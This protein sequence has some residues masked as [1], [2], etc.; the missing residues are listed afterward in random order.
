MEYNQGA[1]YTKDEYQKT[2][3]AKN[4]NTI[5]PV[6]LQW[7]SEHVHVDQNKVLHL[8]QQE[9]YFV[10]FVGKVLQI[11]ERKNITEYTV[12]DYTGSIKCMLSLINKTQ[13]NMV[14][15]EQMI[16]KGDYVYVVAR[17][18]RRDNDQSGNQ[19]T[20]YWASKIKRIEDH[21]QLTKHYLSCLVEELRARGQYVQPPSKRDEAKAKLEEAEAAVY[22]CLDQHA[23]THN[24]ISGVRED[25]ILR[26][27]GNVPKHEVM[28]VLTSIQ[29]GQNTKMGSDET[30][31]FLI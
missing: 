28:Q 14:K 30:G 25:Q 7:L 19:E 31:Y 6:L 16:T 10:T 17:G 20:T 27:C 24:Q 13:E 9:L 29:Q 12:Q 11:D 21:N 15:E 8:F 22:R 18:S 23:T 4:T 5:K 1:N 3:R 2:Q 26:E